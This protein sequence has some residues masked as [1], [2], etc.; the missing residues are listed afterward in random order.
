MTLQQFEADLKEACPGLVYHLAA[1]KNVARYVAW[2]CYGYSSAQADDRNQINAPKIQID[3]HTQSVSDLL[4]ED[5][6][7]AL[8]MMDLPY[9]IVSEGYDDEYNDIRTILQLVVI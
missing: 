9:A 2:H 4:V 5:V 6:L 1:P 7:S 8:W 3:I